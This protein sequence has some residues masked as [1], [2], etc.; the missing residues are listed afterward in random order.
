MGRS[1]VR[2]LPSPQWRYVVPGLSVKQAQNL[3]AAW[4]RDP[5]RPLTARAKQIQSIAASRRL[6]ESPYSFATLGPKGEPNEEPRR[7]HQDPN[8]HSTD[9][10]DTGFG[11]G[12][13]Q[14]HRLFV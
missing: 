1:E 7:V 3:P 6:I 5:V 8:Q 4:P 12:A 10:A 14:R 9:R 11:P 2:F 13:Q